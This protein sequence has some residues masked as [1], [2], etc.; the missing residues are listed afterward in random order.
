MMKMTFSA[1]AIVML[2]PMAGFAAPDSGPLELTSSLGRK[3]YAL[4]DDQKL[5]DARAKL[6]ADPKNVD[7]IV[8]LSKAQAARRQ[9]KEA[10]ATDTEGLAQAPNNGTLLLERGHYELGLRE[11]AAAKRDLKRA[12]E[13]TPE[14]LEVFYH[15]GLAHYFL[16]EFADAGADFGKA[17]DLSKNDDGVISASNWMYASLRRA[18]EDAQAA[19]VLKRITP[20]MKNTDPHELFYLK[21]LRFFQGT[22]PEQDV[23]P[24]APQGDDLEAELA[25]DTTA[26]G[27][28]NWALTHHQQKHAKELFSRVVQGQAWNSFGFV[29]SEL[30]LTRKK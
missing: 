27:I 2:L 7:L 1:L 17:R 26:Y 30:E 20:Q 18:G 9:Y 29:G 10:V 25:F 3:L 6:A 12:A 24:P 13:A 21:L 28:G 22:M 19:E 4:P 15:L 11:F 23:L 14:V 5:V 8:A 16:G